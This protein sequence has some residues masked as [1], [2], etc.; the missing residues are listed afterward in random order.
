MTGSAV[1][2]NWLAVSRMRRELGLGRQYYDLKTSQLSGGELSRLGLASVL[3]ADA[4][5]LLLDEPTNHL[6]WEA[7]LWLERFL[8]NYK[9]AAL[10]VSHD[11]FLLDR[12][13]TKI[14]EISDCRVNL[15][16]G[17]YSNYKREKTKRDLELG[18]QHQQR[19]EFI[20][21]TR[22][23]IARNKDREGTRKVA[24]GRKKYLERILHHNP[25]FLDRPKQDKKLRFKFAEVERTTKRQEAV[26]LCKNLS[27]RFDE[28][29]LFKDIGFELAVGGRLGIIGPNGTGKTTLLKLLLGK[30]EA[31]SGKIER[32]KNLTIGYLDQAAVEINPANT[33]LEE[34]SEAAPQLTNEQ[35]RGMLGAFLFSGDDVFKK[36]GNL[37]GGERNRLALCRLV[38]AG[39]DVLVL[40]EPTN[41]LD[42]PA[43]EA[44]EDAL[45][46]YD[47][48][49]IVVSH[50]R[51]FLDKIADKLIVL[52]TDELGKKA[53]GRFEIV[54]GT[55]SRY[56]E[57][58]E[59]RTA[60]QNQKRR[61]GGAAKPKR[62]KRKRVKKTTPSHLRRFNAWS[63][64]KIEEEIIKTEEQLAVL[65]EQ[66]GQEKIY[67]DP[68]L[69][70]ALE[71][72]FGSQK[73]YLAL[74]YEVYELRS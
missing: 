49:V 43:I 14:M 44:L 13:V 38:L 53:L 29:V 45:V 5:L 2:L 65:E 64:E 46:D 56:S 22:S 71:K 61:S 25:D 30:I 60:A 33:V 67:K 58:L 7:R 6:D 68:N 15:Y 21:R 19:R 10:I 52:G 23:F 54:N 62:P 8:K 70:S 36:T 17:N 40:D 57:L 11:R 24:R 55:F 69:F 4:E 51:F 48:T 12:L 63:L 72:D 59:E 18:R 9:G 66:F 74:L 42:I 27:K 50:D 34:A 47:G 73:D 26:I 37:S 32:K 16:P 35:L 1:S 3:L 39:P 28:I 20:E 31:T 41:H